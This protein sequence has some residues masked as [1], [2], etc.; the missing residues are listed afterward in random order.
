ME[1]PVRPEFEVIIDA[2]ATMITLVEIAKA[3]HARE[4]RIEDAAQK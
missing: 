3:R 1:V 4:R 2:R